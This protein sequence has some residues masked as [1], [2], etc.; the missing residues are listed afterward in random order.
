MFKYSIISLDDLNSIANNVET[1][2]RDMP[3]NVELLKA[4]RLSLPTCRPF[5]AVDA[6]KRNAEYR[7]WCALRNELVRTIKTLEA[8]Q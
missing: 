2:D 6:I 8:Q 4:I 3:C 7:I 5:G 1:L